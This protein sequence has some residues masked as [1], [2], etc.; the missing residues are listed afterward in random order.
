MAIA[1]GHFMNFAPSGAINELLE[2]DDTTLEDLLDQ[3]AV[4]S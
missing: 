1:L 2:K 4:V 3:E